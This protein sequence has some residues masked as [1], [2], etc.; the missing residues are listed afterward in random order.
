MKT[1][2]I[3]SIYLF[4]ALTLILSSLFYFLII[5]SGHIAG[6]S[7]LF[8]T[9]LMWSPGIA[10]LITCLILNLKVSKLGWQ[11]GKNIFQIWS[12]LIPLFYS[13]AAYCIIWSFDSGSFYNKIFLVLKAEA[14]G[15]KNTSP[16][17]MMLIYV[18][19]TGTIGI[20]KSCANALGEE[21]G[22]R[23][24]LV[25]RL[26]NKLGYS[27]TA[28]LSGLIWSFWHYPILLF[29]DYNSQTPMW[30]ALGCF[31]ILTVSLG[32]TYTWM[33][34]K[35]GSLWT[36]VLLHASHNLFI[37]SVFTPLTNDSGNTKYFIDEFGIAIP[38][39]TTLIAVYFWFRRKELILQNAIKS[40]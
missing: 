32:F 9:G 26:F 24:F 40:V 30:Y 3:K 2:P 8:S 6:G 20:I 13:L 37:Q 15:F 18:S 28:L 12:Y 7:G 31:T 36:S 21:I 29:A 14:F 16:L 38:I 25:P 10:A 34:I 4:L 22:W 27:K 1:E 23:G 11:W 5:H 39:A 35:S 19:F 17:L 33:R